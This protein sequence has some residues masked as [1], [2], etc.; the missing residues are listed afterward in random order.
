MSVHAAYAGMAGALKVYYAK[1]YRIQGK[2]RPTRISVSGIF[3]S[4][5]YPLCKGRTRLQTAPG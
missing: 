2:G 4:L 5:T 1:K 3:V